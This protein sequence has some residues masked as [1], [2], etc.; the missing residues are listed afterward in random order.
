M[1]LWKRKL[2]GGG[3]GIVVVG[4]KIRQRRLGNG[5]GRFCVL[6]LGGK[7]RVTQLFSGLC[8]PAGKALGENGGNG[9]GLVERRKKG[10]FGAF[11]E[12]Q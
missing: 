9:L 7:G 8:Y 1:R 10:T 12:F 2:Q 11:S 3:E 4:G 6:F 5:G